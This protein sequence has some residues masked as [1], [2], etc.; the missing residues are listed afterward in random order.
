MITVKTTI[1]LSLK[2]VWDFW[3]SPEHIEKWNF[4]SEDWHCPKAV[5]DLRPDGKFSYTMAAK[6][7]SVAF[8]FTGKYTSI[9]PFSAISYQIEDGRKVTV[10]F[11]FKEGSTHITE[12]FE[13][14]TIH[15]HELQ[16]QGWQSILDEF[17]RYATKQG[18]VK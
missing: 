9:L 7:G 15:S 14:E 16:Q 6:D 11:E 5:N 1:P 17:G 13:P 3:T 18:G 10:E 12:R 8:D 4:A 2:E